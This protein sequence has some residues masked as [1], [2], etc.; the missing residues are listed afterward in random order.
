MHI[1][2]AHAIQ[3][4]T[5]VLMQFAV[6]AMQQATQHVPKHDCAWCLVRVVTVIVTFCFCGAAAAPS[7]ALEEFCK[8]GI[9]IQAVTYL[10]LYLCQ[11]CLVLDLFA[12]MLGAGPV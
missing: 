3:R 4:L 11:P 8:A 6:A 2:D 12:A 7:A 5:K 10:P 1:T 9:A